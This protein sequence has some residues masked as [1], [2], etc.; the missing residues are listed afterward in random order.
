MPLIHYWPLDEA[1][2]TTAAEKIAG[3]SSPIINDTAGDSAGFAGKFGACRNFGA[4][5]GGT[6]HLRFWGGA[7][8]LS[9]ALPEWSFSCWLR[10]DETS[11]AAS[12]SI[13]V[14]VTGNWNTGYETVY[15][16][17][18][19]DGN[20]MGLDIAGS[21]EGWQYPG[22]DALW[23]TG[24]HL[25]SV[26][27]NGSSTVVLLDGEAIAQVN[28][29]VP[30]QLKGQYSE[31]GGT[32]GTSY[33]DMRI[34]DVGVFDHAIGVIG[35]REIWNAGVGS[36]PDAANRMASAPAGEPSVEMLAGAA[37]PMAQAIP[38]AEMFVDWVAVIDP[39][40][41]NTY[42]A[43]DIEADGFETIR[44]PM[45]SWQATLQIDRASYVQAVIPAATQWADAIDDRSSGEFIIRR[46]AR[47][48]GGSVQ[49]TE[50]ARAP[51]T[52]PRMNEGPTK[53]TLTLTGYTTTAAPA[54]GT[55][56]R[57]L[58]HVRSQSAS[59]GQRARCAIDWK[60]RPGE[61]VDA[62]GRVF[63]AGYI[64]YYANVGDQYMDVGERA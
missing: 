25:V 39:L 54:D 64:N 57:T 19:A 31:L 18:D 24:W 17:I 37:A 6:S 5:L 13:P 60:L 59:P 53:A 42:Y 43:C 7:E 36:L 1:T 3:W 23:G 32:D 58:E 14:L 27:C 55:V 2:G 62:R 10:R 15:L 34:D 46:G 56:V 35:H 16:S 29:A 48:E 50:L 47:F 9:Y 33:T 21:E 28:A 26:S 20:G 11:D 61:Q 22:V 41:T 38:S 8:D 63:T 52:T 4:A 12:F 40:T 30:L 45:S 49:E 51:V 44:V